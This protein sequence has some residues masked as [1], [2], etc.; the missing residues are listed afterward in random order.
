MQSLGKNID[1]RNKMTRILCDMTGCKHNNSCCLSTAEK[2]YCTKE[3]VHFTVDEA[4]CQLECSNFEE[5]MEKEVECRNCQIQKVKRHRE[6]LNT[7]D[8]LLKQSAILCLPFSLKKTKT[9]ISA[10]GCL[11]YKMIWKACLIRKGV[12]NYER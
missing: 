3:E 4:M 10:T 6:W 7:V 12:I 11:H 8:R 2:S 9:M 5:S 1:R